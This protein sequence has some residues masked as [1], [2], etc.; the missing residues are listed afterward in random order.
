MLFL[1][2]GVVHFCGVVRFGVVYRCWLLPR[3]WLFVAV[4]VFHVAV[5]IFALFGSSR[6]C[7]VRT[8]IRPLQVDDYACTSGVW[9]WGLRV[10][11]SCCFF[12]ENPESNSVSDFAR[13]KHRFFRNRRSGIPVSCVGPWRWKVSSPVAHSLCQVQC[14][15]TR[16]VR[17]GCKVK[18]LMDGLD[19]CVHACE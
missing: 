11:F 7:R 16:R 12:C 1:F 10:L 8:R 18:Y 6:T 9:G 5:F 19:L 13:P 15:R 14:V 2:C 4:F 17:T 3:C